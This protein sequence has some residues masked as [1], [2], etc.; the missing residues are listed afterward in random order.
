MPTRMLSEAAAR[1]RSATRST[2][3][4]ST[5]LQGSPRNNSRKYLIVS[6]DEMTDQSLRGG[7]ATKPSP[8][9]AGGGDPEGRYARTPML[10]I[11]VTDKE[12]PMY[13]RSSALAAVVVLIVV[14][15][16][17]PAAQSAEVG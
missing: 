5:G 9:T 8:A 11:L 3:R 7:F 17:A 15:L 4:D 10:K 13:S 16:L 1:R 14:L 12:G 6:G 2:C